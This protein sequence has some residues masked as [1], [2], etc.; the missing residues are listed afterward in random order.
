MFI[1]DIP[2]R[3]LNNLTGQMNIVKVA[4]TIQDVSA[5]AEYGKTAQIAVNAWKISAIHA[6]IPCRSGTVDLR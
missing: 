2:V 5:V 6:K 3:Q 4:P 1:G